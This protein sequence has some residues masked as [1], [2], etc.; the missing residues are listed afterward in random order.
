MVPRMSKV[1]NLLTFVFLQV[2][3]EPMAVAGTLT[4][5]L[6]DTMPLFLSDGEY[7]TYLRV[8]DFSNTVYGNGAYGNGGNGANNFG[9]DYNGGVFGRD[10]G[11][12][13]AYAGYGSY[14]INGDY[15]VSTARR[16]GV[17]QAGGAE[18]G[19]GVFGAGY[20]SSG[21]NGGYGT[22]RVG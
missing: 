15:S 1:A 8:P 20:R 19:N 17:A 3:L 10:Y 16:V 22:R 9:G 11:M 4:S 2:V 5:A 18:Y 21:V 6:A 7:S 14:G 13:R 12:G